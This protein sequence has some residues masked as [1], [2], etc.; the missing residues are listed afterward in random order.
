MEVG[1]QGRGGR[2]RGGVGFFVFDLSPWS[3]LSVCVCA[4]RWHCLVRLRC[5]L[6]LPILGNAS[7]NGA[8]SGW[9]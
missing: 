5:V 8:S 3:F 7:V 6:A 4:R 2:G 9:C 1:R